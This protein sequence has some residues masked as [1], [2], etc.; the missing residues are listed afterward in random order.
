MDYLH[1][2]AVERYQQ[3]KTLELLTELTHRLL[4]IETELKTIKNK[5]VKK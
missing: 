5:M 1:Y 3:E 4:K 2:I